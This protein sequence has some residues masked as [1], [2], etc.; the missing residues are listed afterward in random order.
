MF[1]IL[2]LHF[3]CTVKQSLLVDFGS[4]NIILYDKSCIMMVNVGIFTVDSL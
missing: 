1:Q 3:N 4:F 2:P